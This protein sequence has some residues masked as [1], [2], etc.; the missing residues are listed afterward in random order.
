MKMPRSTRGSALTLVGVALIVGVA[1]IV[2]PRITGDSLS[3]SNETTI[4]IDLLV[5][6]A[7]VATMAPGSDGNIPGIRLPAEPWAVQA[8]TSG[9]RVLSSMTVRPGDVVEASNYEKGDA[10]RV[11]LSCGRLDIWVGAPLNGPAPQP[12]KSGDCAP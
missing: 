2:L 10:V 6:G 3:Y 4:S 8:Q 12:G 9:G 11:D 1:V 7:K 5:N